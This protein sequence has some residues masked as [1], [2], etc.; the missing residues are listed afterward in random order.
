MWPGEGSDH[1]YK[2][3]SAGITQGLAAGREGGKD[4]SQL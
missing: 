1:A 3:E 2:K 4:A